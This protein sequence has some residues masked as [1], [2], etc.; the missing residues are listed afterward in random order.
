M[1]PSGAACCVGKIMDKKANEMLRSFKRERKLA[2]RE[3]ARERQAERAAKQT[4]WSRALQGVVPLK[5]KG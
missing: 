4:G 2:E 1:L 3:R 5:A